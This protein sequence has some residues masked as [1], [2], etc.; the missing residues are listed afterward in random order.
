VA[1]DDFVDAALKNGGVDR[2]IERYGERQIVEGVA[3]F[4]LVQKPQA[5][6]RKRQREDQIVLSDRTAPG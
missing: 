2:N 6:L 3:R 1:V 5:P 4:E